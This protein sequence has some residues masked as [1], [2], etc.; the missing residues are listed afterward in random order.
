M[1]DFKLLF[2]DH[3]AVTPTD[4][5]KC[6]LIVDDIQLNRELLVDLL[7]PNGYRTIQAEDGLQALEII[8]ESSP[9][10]VLLDIMMPR[11]NGFEVCK[12]MKSSLAT[13]FIPVVMITALDDKKDKIRGIEAGADDFINKPFDQEALISRVRSLMKMKTL[14]ESFEKERHIVDTLLHCILP[15][16]IIEELK[17]HGFVKPRRYNNVTVLFCQGDF[18]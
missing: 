10:L 3:N 9:D 12:A 15:S 8:G 6:I 11:M 13:S 5:A 14:H 2:E 17:Q 18:I 4:D 16:K 1:D 7:E